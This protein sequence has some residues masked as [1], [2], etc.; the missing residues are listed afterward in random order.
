MTVLKGWIFDAYLVSNGISLWIIDEAGRMHTLLDP[1]QPKLFVGACA[2]LK[3]LLESW[4]A[5]LRQT[6]KKEFY[7]NTFV[8]VH[9]IRVHNPQTY[10]DL[11]RRLEQVEGLELYN[12]DIPLIQ[13]YHYERKHFPLARGEY[14]PDANGKGKVFSLVVISL[15]E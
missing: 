6:D 1:W 3:R 13:A 11:V 15:D 10:E 8:P 2:D 9:E 14:E 5:T 12:A 4:P 7:S